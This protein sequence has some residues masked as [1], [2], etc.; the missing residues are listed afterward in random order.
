MGQKRARS[1]YY[2]R[3]KPGERFEVE[4]IDSD[5]GLSRS[6][7]PL[8]TT[9]DLARDSLT[10]LRRFVLALRSGKVG[11]ASRLVVQ[12]ESD[13]SGS[14]DHLARVAEWSTAEPGE[15]GGDE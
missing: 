6:G 7:E 8:P 12:M 11:F 14:Y 15:G 10:E 9:E 2:V 5:P 3:L 4:R 13:R 1:L